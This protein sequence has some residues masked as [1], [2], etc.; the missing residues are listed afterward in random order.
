VERARRTLIR[1]E[2]GF[3]S[4]GATK[5]STGFRSD[6]KRNHGTA[7]Q[8]WSRLPDAIASFGARLRG[9]L[10]E[11]RDA[12]QVIAD[13]DT[14]HT[15]FYVDP[16]YLPNTRWRAGHAYRCEMSDAEHSALLELLT[17]VQGM[18]MLSG[19][20]SPLYDTR[21]AH[22]TRVARRAH[23]AGQAGSVPRTEVLWLSPNVPV[24]GFDFG[25]A[26]L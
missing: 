17:G 8:V 7:M 26:A 20:A 21:L 23:G 22:W 12:C 25:R 15:L 9:V 10:I 19:Y 4:A 24:S 11:N 14:P 2:M 6:T 5:Q 18:V 13:H 3:G 16:P 1:A